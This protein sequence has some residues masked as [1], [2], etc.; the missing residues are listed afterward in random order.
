M[1]TV[2]VTIAAIFALAGA[3]HAAEEHSIDSVDTESGTVELDDG[4]TYH[5]ND[6]IDTWSAGDTVLVPSSGDRLINKD[7]DEGVDATQE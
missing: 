2:T 5:T 4:T 6:T 7:E 1:R 3:A